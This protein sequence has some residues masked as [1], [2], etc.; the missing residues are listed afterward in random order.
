MF[1]THFSGCSFV[2][3]R[4]QRRVE[5]HQP[6]LTLLYVSEMEKD[7]ESLGDLSAYCKNN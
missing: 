6:D 1:R 2:G 3:D 7:D 5:I 4:E